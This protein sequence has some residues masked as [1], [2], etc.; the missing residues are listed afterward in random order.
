MTTLALPSAAVVDHLDPLQQAVYGYLAKYRCPSTYR[1][2]RED[3]LNWLDWCNRQQLAPLTVRRVHLD[4]YVRWMQDQ[5][6]WAEST[7]SRRIGTVRGMYRYAALEDI[8]VK[9]PGAGLEMP[10]VDRDKQRRTVLSPIDFALLLRAAERYGVDAHALVALMGMMGLRIAELCSLNVESVTTDRGYRALDFI[11]KGNRAA[12]VAIPIPVMGIVEDVI[13]GRS[14]GPLVRN[15]RGER[16][17]RPTAA[18]L[19]RRL[20]RTAGVETDFSCHSLRRSF[21][22]TGLIFGVDIYEMSIAM[23]HKSVKTTALYDGARTNLHRNATHQV[24]GR[25][26]ALT[27]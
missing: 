14:E 27:G 4:L 6:R 11:G 1:A 12:H 3:L 7:I 20:A 10:T 16:I 2:Y 17:D 23:R 18:R 5:N 9:D 8:I 15:R 25:M 19:L 21:C 13:D 26:A 24:A 22:T